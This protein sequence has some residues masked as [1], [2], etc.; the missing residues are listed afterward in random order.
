M[1]GIG[2]ADEP[3]F[4]PNDGLL[5]INWAAART[6]KSRSPTPLGDRVAN[7]QAGVGLAS[8]LHGRKVRMAEQ[9]YGGAGRSR[10]PTDPKLEDAGNR[11]LMLT[12]I[13]PTEDSLPQALTPILKD[14]FGA[15]VSMTEPIS[16]PE[17]AY[18][19]SRRQYH[20]TVLL[21]ALAQRKRP[22]WER[23]LGIDETDRKGTCF[24]AAHADALRLTIDQHSSCRRR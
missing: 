8:A 14:A 21:D 12:W 15:A 17:H 10:A 18:S 3:Q 4:A 7:T 9:H 16:L 1:P 13:G 2:D 23:L 5:L 22:E 6:P 24:C 19:A 20:S 11:L